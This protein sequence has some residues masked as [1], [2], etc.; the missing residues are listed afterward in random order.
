MRHIVIFYDYYYCHSLFS[1][2]EVYVPPDLQQVGMIITH[3][4]S[5]TTLMWHHGHGELTAV[6]NGKGK[7]KSSFS[8]LRVLLV[9]SDE[10]FSHL[11]RGLTW[12]V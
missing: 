3:K 8:C 2:I 11:Y 6:V 10:T 7:L 9:K 4:K 12:F 1:S 5:I